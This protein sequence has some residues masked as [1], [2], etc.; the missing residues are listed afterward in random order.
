MKQSREFQAFHFSLVSRAQN[1][2]QQWDVFENRR[3]LLNGMVKETTERKYHAPF[4]FLKL[5]F[6]LEILL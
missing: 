5:S 4:T 3:M 2:A 1:G 6:D